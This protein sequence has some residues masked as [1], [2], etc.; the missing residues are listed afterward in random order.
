[1][2]SNN[3]TNTTALMLHLGEGDVSSLVRVAS[4][5]HS[6]GPYS[7]VKLTLGGMEIT[8]FSG[9]RSKEVAEALS[10]AGEELAKAGV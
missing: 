3:P 9:K 5:E 6:G 7:V 4:H 2:N 10:K 1:M 8:I